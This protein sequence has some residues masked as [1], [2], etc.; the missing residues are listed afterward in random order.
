MSS[1]SAD[2]DA[3]LERRRRGP[4]RRTLVVGGVISSVGAVL[5]GLLGGSG[6]SSLAA[7]LVGSA[8]TLG[9]GGVVALGTA[10]RD[11]YRGAR[12]PR[13]RVLVGVGLLLGAPVSLMLA[14][15]A[16]SAA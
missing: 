5:V 8:L 15:G 7:A 10:V 11:E 14:A 13:R 3:E 16:A 6:A 9:I 1:P 2:L 12:V 4:I